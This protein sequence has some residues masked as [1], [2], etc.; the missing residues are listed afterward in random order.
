[1]AINLQ[2]LMIFH[3][4]GT[5]G[6]LWTTIWRP[7]LNTCL[8]PNMY[9]FYVFVSVVVGV[10]CFQSVLLFVRTCASPKQTSLARYL[11]FLFT[12]FDQ[13]FTSDGL[14]SKDERVKFWSQKIRSQGH[15]GV[16][17]A[18]NY[19]FWFCSCHMLTE[20]IIVD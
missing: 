8:I 4:S 7:G 13:T 14:H 20:G 18:P 1:M 3:C 16:K 5:L 10:L 9:V 19:T 15:V 2:Y 17:Y 12:E 6:T 11:G